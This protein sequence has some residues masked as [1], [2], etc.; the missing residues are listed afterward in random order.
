MSKPRR[1]P[2]RRATVAKGKAAPEPP[3]WDMSC[4]DWKNRILN[5]KSLVP[6]LPLNLLEADRAV[7]IFDAL[8]LPDVSGCPLMKDAAPDWI[9]DVVRAMFGAYDPVA[10]VRHIQE[11]FLLVPKKN[12]KSSFAAAI[13]IVAILMNRRPLAELLLIAPTIEVAKIAFRQARGI[14][15]ADPVLEKKF[16]VQD[17]L[18]QITYVPTGS[19]LAIKASD[20]DT[21]TG[22]KWTF[23]LIDETHVFAS[24]S[25]A[26]DV[27]LEIRGAL[28]A[29]PD[30]FLFQ[31]TTQSKD[32]PA[33]VFKDEL[34]NA[35]AVRD[36]TLKLRLL[37]ILYELPEEL[38][39]DAWRDEKNWSLVNPNL[40][41]SVNPV[42]LR[43]QLLKAEENG[44]EQLALFASQHFNVEIGLR[45]RANR[46]GGAD[47][48]ESAV[49]RSLTLTTLLQRSE[50]VTIGIDG[51][52]LDDL[53]GL[54]ITGREKGTRN[55][56]MWFHAWACEIVLERRKEI[57]A[58]LR[59]FEVAGDL[60]IYGEDELGA[61]IEE[62][63]VYV[64]QVSA[65]GLLPVKDGIGVDAAGIGEI[66]D[67]LMDPDGPG[68]PKSAIV[69]VPQGWKLWGVI[70]SLERRL[71][72]RTSLHGGQPLAAWAVG[73]AKLE[74]RGNAM[75]M[76][77]SAAGRAK[78]DPVIAALNA[79]M[80]MDQNP[81]VKPP[82]VY[83]TR[84]IRVL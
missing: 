32:T 35:R 49:D 19:T 55:R 13:M 33:G 66:P 37:P 31:I 81:T 52:G 43:E 71:K 69:A 73:N 26:A 40:G 11:L 53:L 25:K 2:S 15:K 30:G 22:G 76:T 12:G 27:F 75:V 83:E 4:P 17:H 3:V 14:I 54:C 34:A 23:V 51:G 80:L 24:K 78:I 56:L 38:G 62:L 45:L 44:P 57:A 58:T 16:H 42:F 72:S 28:A 60:T 59:D 10:N 8:R 29:R 41:R 1:A 7:Q 84:G 68:L 74:P 18:K 67:A 79:E 61:D 63:C 36:G 9:R 70:Q 48:W 50:C 64:E 20:T 65:S 5:G 82:S 6:E 77:K 21:I 46:W 39:P 47:Y